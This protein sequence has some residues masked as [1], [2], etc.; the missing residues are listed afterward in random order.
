MESF[1]ERDER[2]GLGRAQVVSIGRHIAAAL[3][4][5]PDEL[6]GRKPHRDAIQ[7]WS[8]LSARI[9]EGVAVAALLYLKHQRTLPLER[10]RALYVFV[11]HRLAG[12]RHPPP[13]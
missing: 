13:T 7:G 2:R 5:L 12:P 9:A 11:R 8:P 6:V 1:K 3:D 10:G 4:H